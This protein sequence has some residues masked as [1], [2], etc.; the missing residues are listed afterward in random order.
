MRNSF[1]KFIILQT[2]TAELENT[3]NVETDWDDL[4]TVLQTC[5]PVEDQDK[6][7]VGTQSA[8]EKPLKTVFTVKF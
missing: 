5:Y 1:W 3:N 4:K 7:Q 6:C 8:L 2:I